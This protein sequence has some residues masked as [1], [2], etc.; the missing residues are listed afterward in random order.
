MS[1]TNQESKFGDTVEAVCAQVF[2]EVG[3]SM[4]LQGPQGDPGST[5][6]AGPQGNDG[7]QG[8]Q[9]DS[10]SVG[11]QGSGGGGAGAG[12]FLL[13]SVAELDNPVT[14][15]PFNNAVSLALSGG[16]AGVV[17]FSGMYVTTGLGSAGTVTVTLSY[18]GGGNPTFVRSFGIT[19]ASTIR[20]VPLIVADTTTLTGG[21]PYT[22]VS[23]SISDTLS[24]SVAEG[25]LVLELYE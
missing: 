21:H 8:P 18:T 4:G 2:E 25:T 20:N 23:V 11:P 17:R 15:L 12:Q 5:G 10:G 1:Q 22:N 19:D 14:P 6:S 16:N 13:R 24:S 7:S 3:G 9:G